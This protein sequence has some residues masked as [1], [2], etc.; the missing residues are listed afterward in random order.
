[1]GKDKTICSNYRPIAL[2][3][4]DTKIYAKILALRLK[5]YMPEWVDPDQTGFVPG[6][7]GRDNS[8]KT[9]L[10]LQK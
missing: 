1:M 3:N 2:L 9:M 10:M 6:R 4:A 7:E 8:I 5:K